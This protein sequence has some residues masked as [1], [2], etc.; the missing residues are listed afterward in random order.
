MYLSISSKTVVLLFFLLSEALFSCQSKQG[1][2]TDHTHHH[3]ATESTPEVAKAEQAV[4]AVHDEV[5]PLISQVMSQKR[6]AN[7]RIKQLDSLQTVQPKATTIAT[8]KT[9]LQTLVQELENADKAMSDWMHAYD[10][11][12]E[13]KSNAEALAYLQEQQQQI[14]AVQAKVLASL[15]HSKQLL[16]VPGG[17][18]SL[19]S[20]LSDSTHSMK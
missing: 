8:E 7:E 18:T 14:M 9:Q 15:R 11:N 19:Q 2:S 5:M 20:A 12:R 16:P 17:P 6:K 3:D 13:G 4:L 10:S 1:D